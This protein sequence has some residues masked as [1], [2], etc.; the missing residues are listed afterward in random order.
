VDDP[1]PRMQRFVT[2]YRT[3]YGKPPENAFAMLGYDTLNL[4]VDAIRRAGVAAPEAVREALAATRDFRGVT[5]TIGY[6]PGQRKPS[7]PVTIMRIRDGAY[8]FVK[9][10]AP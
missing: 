3:A 10:V 5:G 8:A 7:K 4:I 1:D 9:S 6:R 2:D